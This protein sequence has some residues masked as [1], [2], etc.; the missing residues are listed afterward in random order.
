MP[1]ESIVLGA[2]VAAN[3]LSKLFGKAKQN[4]AYG[5]VKDGM[6]N[7]HTASSSIHENRDIIPKK[8]IMFHV[9]KGQECVVYI[10]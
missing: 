8:D 9:D 7:L 1:A 4:T 5:Q 10:L 6:N 3:A 2:P